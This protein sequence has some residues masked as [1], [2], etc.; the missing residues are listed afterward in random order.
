MT[1]GGGWEVCSRWSRGDTAR[2]ELEDRASLHG[3]RGA[4]GTEPR[5]H[6]LAGS[7]PALAFEHADNSERDPRHGEESLVVATQLF[8]VHNVQT[9]ARILETEAGRVVGNQLLHV[10]GLERPTHRIE[11]GASHAVLVYDYRRDTTRSAE[12]GTAES[13]NQKPAPRLRPSTSNQ[14]P[15]TSNQQPATSN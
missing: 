9:R 8:P 2:V 4:I 14:Q 7:A 6:P 13:H 15:A 10:Q 11:Q 3:E 1:P 5:P 12:V